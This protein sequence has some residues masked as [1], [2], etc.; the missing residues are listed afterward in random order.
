MG[1][2]GGWR[3]CQC[4]I[5]RRKGG[6]GMRGAGEG[7]TPL[8][9]CS[10]RRDL[11]TLSRA[12]VVSCHAHALSVAKLS[13]LA[14]AT[15]IYYCRYINDRKKDCAVCNECEIIRRIYGVFGPFVNEYP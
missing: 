7:G 5:V 10:V 13:A 8:L 3:G 2:G 1:S 14:S 6:L 12:H 11:V 15:L 9:S 4:T